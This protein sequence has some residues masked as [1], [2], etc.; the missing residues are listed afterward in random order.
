MISRFID[1]VCDG[2]V[3]LIENYDAAMKDET[4]VW[5]CHHKLESHFSDGTPRPKDAQLSKKELQALGVYWHRPPEELI[6]LTPK[7]HM[8]LYHKDK[9]FTED[10]KRKIGEAHKGKVVS[11]ETRRK[12]SEAKKG[13]KHAPHSEETKRKMSE[14]WKLRRINYPITEETRRKQSEAMKGKYVGRKHSEETKRKISESKIGK[15]WKLVDGKR[16]YY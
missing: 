15:H 14:A 16:V 10:H 6:F 11:E 9:L 3:S 1:K 2:D 12:L 13:K 5:D 4:K 7:D 8:R